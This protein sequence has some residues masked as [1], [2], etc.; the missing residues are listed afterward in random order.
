MKKEETQ[1][2]EFARVLPLVG[3][4]IGISGVIC[5]SAIT[6]YLGARNRIVGIV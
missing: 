5:V 1:A 2:A 4:T 3:W 6:R